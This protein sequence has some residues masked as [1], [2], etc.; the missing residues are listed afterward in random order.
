MIAR[1]A[2]SFAAGLIFGLGLVI[3]GMINP[4][5]VQN[6][7]DVAGTFDPSL[8]FV[9]GSALA[10]AAVGYRL[11]RPMGRPLFEATFRWPDETDIDPQL[12]SGAAIFGAG[13]GLAGFCPGPAI[14][15]AA[16]GR[17][18][19]YLFLAAMIAG[20]LAWRWLISP[21]LSARPA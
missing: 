15:A 14:S 11:V 7:L 4:A 19:V 16:L 20:I 12:I 8:A 1:L 21:R 13:W 9:M 3:S 10:V 18:E 6:F 5:K 2:S 17:G